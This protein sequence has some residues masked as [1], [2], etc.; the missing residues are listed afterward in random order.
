MGAG[1]AQVA[2]MLRVVPRAT[3]EAWLS[4]AKRAPLVFCTAPDEPG[5]AVDAPDA[6]AAPYAAARGAGAARA[7]GGALRVRV[8]DVLGGRGDVEV[9]DAR[10]LSVAGL[11]AHLAAAY[12]D[13]PAPSRTRLVLCGRRLADTDLLEAVAS[14][15]LVVDGALELHATVQPRV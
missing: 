8:V 3:R 5:A 6:L 14:E 2:D 7:A 11:K 10:G 13:A 4:G 15:A 1:A 9:A 12:A